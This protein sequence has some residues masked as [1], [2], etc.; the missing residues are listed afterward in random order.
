MIQNI[1]NIK[2]NNNIDICIYGNNIENNLIKKF[3]KLPR[4]DIN[5][6]TNVMSVISAPFHCKLY[7]IIILILYFLGKISAL[8]IFVLC[9]SQIIIFFIKYIFKRRRPF[10]SD[11]DIKLL[12][13]MYFD[14]YSFPSGHTMNAFL[15]SYIL[16]KN[17]N[18]DL[19]IIP[20]LVGMSRIFLGVHYP[21]DVV[22]GFLLSKIIISFMLNNK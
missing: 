7:I 20:Y 3:Q 2:S 12:E 8:H 6:V 1:Q 9:S 16:K 13:P 11:N 19:S 18:M 17:I 5:L 22:G 21:T 14:P 10:E 15:L 4:N